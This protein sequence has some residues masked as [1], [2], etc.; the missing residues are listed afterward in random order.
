MLRIARLWGIVQKEA[1]FPSVTKSFAVHHL[2]EPF[3]L[4]SAGRTENLLLMERSKRGGW[5]DSGKEILSVLSPSVSEAK[6]SK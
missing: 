1:N 4:H 5:L 2:E 3:R 6:T